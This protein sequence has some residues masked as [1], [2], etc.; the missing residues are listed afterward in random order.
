MTYKLQ[1]RYDARKSFYGKATVEKEGNK[2]I[3]YSYGTKVAQIEDG[4]ATVFGTYSDITL[5]H[6][7]DFLKQNGFKAENSKQIMEDYKEGGNLHNALLS[8]RIENKDTEKVKKTYSEPS[9]SQSKDVPVMQGERA[10]KIND[11]VQIVA[12]YGDAR[13][14]FNHT[15]TL[16]ID[17]KEVDSAKTHYI[18][19]TWES[20]EFQSVMQKLIEK[21]TKLNSEEKEHAKKWL[22]G[23]RTDWSSFKTTGMIAKLGDVF[24]NTEKEK[25]DWKARML[26]AGLG[27]KGLQMPDDWD[28]LDEKEKKRRLDAVIKMTQEVGEK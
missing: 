3:L 12:R 18:N 27:N 19:R 26:K 9:K 16:Y 1:P 7:K 23:D 21:T 4:R 24:G 13:D 2:I 14:G 8:A 6:I 5:R 20:Y 25:N 22:D 28:K 10:F 11:R 15:A 17:G